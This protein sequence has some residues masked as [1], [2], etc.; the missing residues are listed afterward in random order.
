M[1]TGLL[2]RQCGFVLE[3]RH[4]DQVVFVLAHGF[5]LIRLQIA[6]QIVSISARA[7]AACRLSELSGPVFPTVP[8]GRDLREDECEWSRQSLARINDRLQR[9][10]IERGHTTWHQDEVR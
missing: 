3:H 8:L 2:L 1:P 4:P 6:R 5:T 10:K 7:S 9:V